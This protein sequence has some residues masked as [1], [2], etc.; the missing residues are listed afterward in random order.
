MSNIL[1]L[2]LL[3]CVFR[4]SFIPF[5]FT[6]IPRSHTGSTAPALRVHTVGL[7]SIA[8]RGNTSSSAVD[9]SNTRD[10]TEKNCRRSDA[11]PKCHDERNTNSWSR[12]EICLTDKMKEGILFSF[13]MA[14]VILK[15]G[16]GESPTQDTRLREQGRSGGYATALQPMDYTLGRVNY[17]PSPGK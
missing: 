3:I 6:D 8:S 16:R 13:F 14:L 4:L 1:C 17:S 9:L 11:T 7:A 10:A 12:K 5:S 2:F 15:A